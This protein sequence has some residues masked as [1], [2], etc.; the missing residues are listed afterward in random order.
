MMVMGCWGAIRTGGGTRNWRQEW[1]QEQRREGKNG[2]GARAR[3]PGTANTKCKG[4]KETAPPPP[5]GFIGRE[6]CSPE[7]TPRAH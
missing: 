4:K 5:I 6:A 2:S 7:R 1:L 3:E